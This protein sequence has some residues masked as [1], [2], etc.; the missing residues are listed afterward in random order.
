MIG[1]WQSSTK[2]R[3]KA[4]FGNL[5]DGSQIEEESIIAMIVETILEHKSSICGNCEMHIVRR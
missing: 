2:Q 1:G 5:K 4:M 3:E